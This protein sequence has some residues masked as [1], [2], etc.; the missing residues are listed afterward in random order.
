MTVEE[1]NPLRKVRKM[2]VALHN[3]LKQL[4]HKH[5]PKNGDNVVVYFISSGQ[6][7]CTK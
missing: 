6:Y 3:R 1:L 4:E 7:F 2:I 5:N